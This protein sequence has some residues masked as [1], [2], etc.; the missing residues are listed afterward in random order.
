L[1]TLPNTGH[2]SHLEIPLI[3]GEN[4][5]CFTNNLPIPQFRCEF[6]IA[7]ELALCMDDD[8]SVSK[9]LVASLPPRDLRV[10]QHYRLTW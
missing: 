8:L 7:S 10:P 3:V 5:L 9:A 4:I 1:C 2:L 6:F